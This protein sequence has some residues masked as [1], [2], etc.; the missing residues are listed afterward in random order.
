M[1]ATTMTGIKRVLLLCS[2]L[3]IALVALAVTQT[4]WA[5]RRIAFKQAKLIIEFNSTAQDVGVQFFLDSDGWETVS[6]FNPAGVLIYQSTATGSLLEQGGGTELFVES[7]EPP[8]AELPLEDFFEIFQ[9][10]PYRFVGLTPE[11]DRLIGTARF[12]HDIPA[13]PEII[14][15]PPVEDGCTDSVPI[16]VVIDWNEV[17]TD[18]DGAPL[19]I[20]GYEVI[21][22]RAGSHLD[23]DLPAS[24]GTRL[25]VPAEFLLPGTQYLFEILAIELGGNQTITEGCFVTAR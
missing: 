9:E 22:E 7:V 2:A 23:V 25:T 13:G 18:I 3:G 10:G 11:G 21:V 16:P 12:T 8:L 17:M 1:R 4:S 15:P 5:A 6:I 19:D 24:A 20:A 14:A